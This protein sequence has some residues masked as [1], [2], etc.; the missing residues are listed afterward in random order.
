MSC[1]DFIFKSSIT[2]TTLACD[3]AFLFD[4]DEKG[5]LTKEE[6]KEISAEDFAEKSLNQAKD[7]A[8]EAEKLIQN[9]FQEDNDTKAQLQDR[10]LMVDITPSPKESQ[11][12]ETFKDQLDA[13]KISLDNIVEILEKLPKDELIM[14]HKRIF[15]MNHPSLPN[16]LTELCVKMRV[17][18]A[19]SYLETKSKLESKNW[20]SLFDLLTCSLEASNIFADI[21]LLWK[22]Y[23]F[24][25]IQSNI[26]ETQYSLL[27]TMNLMAILIPY[28]ISYSNGIQILITK[29]CY[30]TQRYANY[31]TITKFLL[32]INLT[33][34]GLAYFMFIRLFNIF[35]MF[36]KALVLPLPTARY[37]KATKD[38]D[39]WIHKIGLERVEYEGIL[40]QLSISQLVFQNSIMLIMN[41]LVLANV[42]SASGIIEQSLGV[43]LA[44]Y[45]STIFNIISTLFSLYNNAKFFKEDFLL[46]SLT[47]MKAKSG[48]VPFTHLI[49]KGELKAII[50]YNLI[51][52]PLPILTSYLGV[53]QTIKFEFSTT[54]IRK[55]YSS[56]LQIKEV[57]NKQEIQIGG[58]FDRVDLSE[59]ALL[60]QEMLQ[61]KIIVNLDG[62]D[63]DFCIDIY[64]KR[65]R[66]MSMKKPINYQITPLTPEKSWN[67]VTPYG[68]S[69]L[70]ICIDSEESSNNYERLF[71]SLIEKNANI[72]YVDPEGTLR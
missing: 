3:I 37:I 60:L 51:R 29:K 70:N 49:Q 71:D 16:F 59:L 26:L 68:Q 38:I 72:N 28:C 67:A 15:K 48:W 45:G 7:S 39:S 27:L 19:S 17:K 69:I 32:W 53:Y 52:I 18:S 44:S 50:N 11:L 36:I 66:A 14:K 62:A 55:L 61:D 41:T 64:I 30:S 63:W 58:C 12:D 24:T 8:I 23:S 46:Y 25:Q 33:F 22:I 47:C 1:L 5:Y 9:P 21:F 42:I 4:S 56:I 65:Q 57:E 31:S 54:S 20:G 35:S 40:Q 6:F 13:D 34:V 10:N 2:P 43:L